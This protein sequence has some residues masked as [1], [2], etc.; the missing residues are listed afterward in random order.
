MRGTE[1]QDPGLQIIQYNPGV[2]LESRSSHR[3]FVQ[4]F[5]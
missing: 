1:G 5:A 3:L 2:V 4:G